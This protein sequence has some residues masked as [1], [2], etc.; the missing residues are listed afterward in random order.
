MQYIFRDGSSKIIPKANGF[1]DYSAQPT[2][3]NRQQPGDSPFIP[4]DPF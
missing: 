2:G 4:T 1:G 3:Y